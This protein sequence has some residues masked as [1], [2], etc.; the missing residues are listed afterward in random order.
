[1]KEMIG[2]VQGTNGATN[3]RKRRMT[4]N[5]V[6]V[7]DDAIKAKT[8]GLV[9]KHNIRIALDGKEN[10]EHSHV[11]DRTLRHEQ[12]VHAS[13]PGDGGSLTCKIT[14]S[15]L[16]VDQKRILLATIKD[17]PGAVLMNDLTSD[18]S[19]LVT[20]A[21]GTKEHCF[22]PRTMKYMLAILRHI[23][24]VS[25]EW[26]M[27][28]ITAGRWIEC[29]RHLI[30]GDEVCGGVTNASK[31]SLRDDKFLFDSLQFYL[32]PNI[33][34]VGRPS[35]QDIKSVIEAGG[36]TIITTKCEGCICLVNGPVKRQSTDPGA[37]MTVAELFMHVSRYER[38]FRTR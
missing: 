38:P 16:T 28:C 13:L 6:I 31:K 21:N 23:P 32:S 1:M 34:Q 5:A 18:C 17:I 11:K 25:F 2:E 12:K 15:S 10:V 30:N 19:L 9:K 8:S 35:R 37:V 36:G 4:C 3:G 26:V 14:T 29:K 33:R 20:N 27:E 7:E 22:A 24:I